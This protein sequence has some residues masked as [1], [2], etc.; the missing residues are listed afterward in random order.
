MPSAW[1]FCFDLTSMV[2]IEEILFFY[3]HW[4]LHANRILY[5]R[6]HK[7]H[8]EWKSSVALAASYAHPF[9]HLISTSL[10]HAIGPLLMGS[11]VITIW[12]FR[13]MSTLFTLNNHSGYH[14]PFLPSAE[15][16]DFHHLKTNVNYGSMGI[17]DYWH[18]TDM[19][20]K[21]TI[22]AVR[23]VTL[24]TM[25]PAKVQYPDKKGK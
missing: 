14:L 19:V 25:V 10:P 21:N 9:E 4:I 1:R 23:H 16:H 13:I 5:T 11:H 24:T 15:A 8:H 22:N 3:S 12:T 6:V 17:L 20:F 18:G 7:K 2:V